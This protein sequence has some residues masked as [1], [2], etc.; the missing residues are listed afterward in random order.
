SFSPDGKFL[1]T[2]KRLP[3]SDVKN[4]SKADQWLT[5]W[6]SLDWKVVHATNFPASGPQSIGR[7]LYLQ[8]AFGSNSDQLAVLA[9]DT[10]RVVSCTGLRELTIIPDKL[11]LALIAR[12]FLALSP[13]NH[14]LAFPSQKRHGVTLWDTERNQELRVLPGHGDIVISG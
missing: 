3:I 7:D 9:G 11:Q 14:T 10:I 8:L 1:L 13:D 4:V 2:G 5:V 6:S 12:P